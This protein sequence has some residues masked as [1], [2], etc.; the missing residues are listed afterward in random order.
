[1]A[2]TL[3]KLSML[4]IAGATELTAAELAD[5]L[6]IR[7]VSG[8][9]ANKRITLAN[10]FKALAL[11]DTDGSPDTGND[12]LLSI[13]ASAGAPK[14]VSM[15]G[16]VGG[17]GGGGIVGNGL[18][19]GR[20]TL[21]SGV[22]LP[23]TNVT[24][25][26]ALYWTP[27]IGNR[28]SLFD[29]SSWV[30][31]ASGERSISLAGLPANTNHDVFG[32]KNGLN[33]D[34]ELLAWTNDSTRATSL[35]KQDGVD[36]KAGDATR[37]YLGM[38]RTVASGQSEDSAGGANTIARRF[39]WNTMNRAPRVIEVRENS[40]TSWTY[41]TGVWRRANNNPNIEARFIV[42][43]A[44]DLIDCASIYGVAAGSSDHY[45]SLA[46][47]WTT[48]GPTNAFNSYGLANA[49]GTNVAHLITPPSPGYHTI[50]PI[51]YGG[52]GVVYYGDVG[53]TGLI[54]RVWG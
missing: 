29:G 7:D 44:G 27:Y 45:M 6:G 37:R 16:F 54:G 12:F 41:T 14:R 22:P 11:L 35:A 42:G 39:V 48:G 5:L 20:L 19:E 31:I 52:T 46:L 51:E 2:K 47:D 18:S 28:I 15:A 36:V 17:G 3:A 49:F 23:T 40:A 10:L 4:D 26:T 53:R 38:I 43:L 32:Y 34:L 30:A 50:V 8:T 9:P 24:A 33:M 25:A 1:M 21:S 13:D